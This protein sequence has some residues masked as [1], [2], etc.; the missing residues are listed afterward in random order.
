MYTLVTP[1]QDMV[2][3]VMRMTILI[4]IHRDSNGSHRYIPWLI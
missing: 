4:D 3:M 2:V 1:M